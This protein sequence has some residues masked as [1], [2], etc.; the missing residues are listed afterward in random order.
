MSDATTRIISTKPVFSAKLFAVEEYKVQ[1]PTGQEVTHQN[2]H[3]KPT[4]YLF[5]VTE[6]YE[7]Y[8]VSEYRYLLGKTIIAGA[9]GFMDKEG[10]KP[11]D[12]AKREAK[13]ELG[14]TA[15]QWEQFAT[16]ELG[17]SVIRAQSHLFLVRDLA[18]GEASPEEDEQIE[19]VKM[20]MDEAVKKVMFGEITSSAT[21]VGILMLDKMRKEGKL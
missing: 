8:L 13:E 4:V 6:K 16:I 19:I 15:Q 1:L 5:P 10:E 12:T 7:L 3:R 17:S 9:A 20:P 21:M 2:I 18:L 11:L 14:I